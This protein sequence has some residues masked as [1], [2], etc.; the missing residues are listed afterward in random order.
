[1][2]EFVCQKL[3]CL[4]SYLA[5]MLYFVSGSTELSSDLTVDVIVCVQSHETLV[6][7]ER[8]YVDTGDPGPEAELRGNISEQF[9]CDNVT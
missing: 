5:Q 9:T 2:N 6:V 1:M 8:I 7:R 3:R 4:S